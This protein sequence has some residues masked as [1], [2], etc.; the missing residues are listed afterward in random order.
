M[1]SLA[2]RL[3]NQR[4][5]ALPMAML[6]LLILSALVV[7]FSVLSA[8]E[9]T[10]ANNQ[11]RVAQA[12]SVAEAGIEQA[13]WALNFG[14]TNPTA[15]NAIPPSLTDTAASPYDGSQLTALISAGGA[16][17]GSFQ[18][19]VAGDGS[20]L[21]RT[22][23]A[24]GWAPST[25]ANQK[26]H[27]RITMKVV[28]PPALPAP[29]AALSV[30]GNLDAGGTSMV[31]SRSDPTPSG[32]S[33]CSGAKLGT[34]TSGDTSTGGS[35]KIWGATDT[36]SSSSSTPNDIT[37]AQ[38]GPIPADP[39]DG[40]ENVSTSVFD[41]Y[42]LKDSDIDA[43]RAYAKTHGTYLQGTVNFCSTCLLPNGQPA[44]LKN[45]I[46]FIDTVS[47]NN[48]T[49]EGVS[50]PTPPSDFADVTIHGNPTDPTNNP[51]DVFS[52]WLFV[53]GSLRI[54]GNFTAHGLVY[55]QND[56]AYRGIGTGQIDG[57]VMSRNIRDVSS[58][59]VDSD[60][61]GNALIRYNCGWAKNGGG[62]FQTWA[63][64]PGTYKE[65]SD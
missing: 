18:V 49:Q 25:T 38:G 4:G 50:P 45:G 60:T 33:G 10:I 54:D 32:T 30:R 8:T 36:D 3:N 56:I 35:A 44:L 40:V 53:N 2:Q 29:P 1:K 37:D 62:M 51:A 42:V 59:S 24:V 46:V 23:S 13:V 65:L 7:G 12:R 22:I 9:P 20:L 55:A 17:I 6:V 64:Q 52:G 41:P 31:D 57:A 5:V 63:M 58:T 47:G 15:Q 14:L 19:T 39:K 28:G 21:G 61:Y 27:Q 34:L 26:A 11:L 43:L 48:I 16:T